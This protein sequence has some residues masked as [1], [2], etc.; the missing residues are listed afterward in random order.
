MRP[1]LAHTLKQIRGTVWQQEY[2]QK[3]KEPRNR[4]E[5]NLLFDGH[6]VACTGAV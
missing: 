1:V 5:M 2:Q 3:I 6:P 4:F